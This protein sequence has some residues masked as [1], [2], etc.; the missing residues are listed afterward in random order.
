MANS[1]ELISPKATIDE[2]MGPKPNSVKFDV[3]DMSNPVLEKWN[4]VC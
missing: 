2:E 1:D 4:E 3:V